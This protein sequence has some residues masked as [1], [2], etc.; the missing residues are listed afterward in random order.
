MAG[1]IREFSSSAVLTHG[2]GVCPFPALIPA[3][4]VEGLTPAQV[5]ATE[6]GLSTAMTYAGATWQR[7]TDHHNAPDN[8]LS[9]IPRSL[10][11]LFC[12]FSK[13]VPNAPELAPGSFTHCGKDPGLSP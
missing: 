7:M 12:F 9:R 13:S 11:R 8:P 3:R 4:A 5:E 2:H 10:L 6:E 1:A